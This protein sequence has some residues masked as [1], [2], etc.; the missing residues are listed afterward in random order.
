M[1]TLPF[2]S[3]CVDWP[4]PVPLLTELVDDSREI[5]RRTFLKYVDREEMRQIESDFGYERYPSRGLTMANDYAVTY[6][7]SKLHN[8]PS[9]FFVWSAI[10]YV[11]IEPTCLSECTE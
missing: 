11:F 3:T 2:F 10:E 4:L 1:P 8:C 9:V 7:R 5:S 6:Y